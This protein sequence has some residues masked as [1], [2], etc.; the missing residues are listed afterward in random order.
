MPQMAFSR[1]STYLS[2]WPI[3][4]GQWEEYFDEQAMFIDLLPSEISQQ[5]AVRLYPKGDYGL[6][7]KSRWQERFPDIA[8]DLGDKPM[9]V[10]LGASCLLLAS[11]NATTYLEGF[12]QN[13]PT[14][15]FW[16][17]DFWE[18]D[19]SAKPYFAIL[20]RAGIFHRSAESAAKHLIDIWPDI[21]QWW[22][23]SETQAARREFCGS[24]AVV[25]HDLVAAMH[26][27]ILDV[28][29]CDGNIK[30]AKC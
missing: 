7:Q 26:R 29:P 1:Y 22:E 27:E 2:S 3:A 28:L 11:Y 19:E 12:V 24:F 8:L 5:L 30:S 20:E 18:L 13:I 6:M 15:I 9:K 10:Q 16:N 14:M 17:P 23:R 25:P 4:A 21:N